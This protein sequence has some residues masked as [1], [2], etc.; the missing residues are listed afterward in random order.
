MA[1]N[2]DKSFDDIEILHGKVYEP[3]KGHKHTILLGQCQ[4]KKNSKNRSI[5]HC[6][7]IEG[8]PPCKE[9]LFEA[10]RELGIEVPDD[11]V[12]QMARLP[13]TFMRNY[14]D[15]PEFDEAFY[16]VQ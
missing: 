9:D 4:V 13:E 16:K 7:K 12:E 15:K 3:S 10:Y 11:F 2:S 14:I 1:K 5:N 8:C 6:I